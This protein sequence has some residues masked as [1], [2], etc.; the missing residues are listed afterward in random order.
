L[1]RVQVMC[2]GVDLPHYIEG[3]NV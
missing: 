1:N 3:A 2:N